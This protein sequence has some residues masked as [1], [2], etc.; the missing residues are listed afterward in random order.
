MFG[1]RWQVRRFVRSAADQPVTVLDIDNTLADA[2]PSLVAPGGSESERLAGLEPLPGMKAIAYDDAVAHDRRIVVM[3]HRHLWH[4]RLTRRWLTDHG[5]DVDPWAVVLVSAASDKPDLIAILSA[6]GRDVEVWDDLS[7]GTES[8]TT[9][10]YTDVV[11]ALER[12]GVRYHGLD[13]IEAVVAEAGGRR[14]APR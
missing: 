11:A 10:R 13:E 4:G 3:S 5:V 2:W 12:L 6:G 8:G 9:Q 7:H 1:A 14:T